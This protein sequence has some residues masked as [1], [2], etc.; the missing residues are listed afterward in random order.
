MATKTISIMEDVYEILRHRKLGDESF[1]D[2][3][4][5]SLRQPDVMEFAGAW[6]HMPDEE[7]KKMKTEIQQR[8]RKGTKE[9]RRRR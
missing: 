3:I 2:V 4:R 5:R 8:R 1:S 7:I 6:E 9:R